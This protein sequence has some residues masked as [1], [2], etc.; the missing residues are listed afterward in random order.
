VILAKTPQ[1][2]CSARERLLSMFNFNTLRQ[3]T[4]NCA[5]SPIMTIEGAAI[6]IAGKP[7]ICG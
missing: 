1:V 6:D 4:A 2:L 5:S 3:L 7:T